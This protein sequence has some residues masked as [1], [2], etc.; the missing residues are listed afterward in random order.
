MISVTI[1]TKNNQSTIASTLESLRSFSEVLVFD[2]GS[3]DHTLKIAASFPNVTIKKGEFLGFGLT[4]NQASSLA[5]YDWILSIDA[6]ESLSQELVSEIKTL[7][8]DTSCVYN[9]KRFN[10]LEN[11]HIKCCAGWHPDSIIRLYHRKQTRFTDDWVHEKVLSDGLK[12][13][14]L[15]YP[16]HH[17][18]YENIDSFLRK[19]QIY[20]SLFAEQ[21]FLRKKSSFFIALFHS[22]SC[23]FK[24]LI[25][26]K[27]LFGGRL[28]WFISLYNAQTTFYKYIKLA[29]KNKKGL[30]CKNLRK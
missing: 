21:H 10:F 11:K 20:S 5:K 22:W 26:K 12:V 6:D 27:G 19:M 23:L 25:L 13:I 4:H 17:T 1:L 2:T 30:T 24:N 14:T 16:I 3:S 9:L 8:L 7:G 28:G 18:P 15:K 29:E